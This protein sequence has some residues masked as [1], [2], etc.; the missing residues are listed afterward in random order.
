MTAC[1]CKR[2]S[3]HFSRFEIQDVGC[4]QSKGRV[5]GETLSGCWSYG[6]FWLRHLVEYEAFSQSGR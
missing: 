5:A 3:A 2:G 6:R 1:V 4:D